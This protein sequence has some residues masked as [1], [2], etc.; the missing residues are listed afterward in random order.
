VPL[1][2]ID[3]HAEICTENIHVHMHSRKKKKKKKKA[4]A[5]THTHYLLFTRTT[6][7][8]DA[9][10][11]VLFCM[12]VVRLF[13]YPVDYRSTGVESSVLQ[14]PSLHLAFLRCEGASPPAATRSRKT[15]V[16]H[17]RIKIKCVY[18]PYLT[19]TEAH[20]SLLQSPARACR[21]VRNPVSRFRSG[22]VLLDTGFQPK[23]N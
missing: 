13:R 7:L 5:H 3:S 11:S 9:E 14:E 19:A 1:H 8:P 22:V 10:P 12:G 21:G 4:A 17:R 6:I 15:H 18:R 20:R 16:A 23:M 2:F